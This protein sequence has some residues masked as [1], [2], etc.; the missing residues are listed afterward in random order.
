MKKVITATGEER[1]NKLLKEKEGILVVSSDIQYQEGIIEA[2]DTYP[3]IDMVILKEDIIGELE[4]KELIHKIIMVNNKIEIILIT[5]QKEG[6]HINQNI[7]VMIEDTENYVKQIVSY[8]FQTS[9]IS[10]LQ[11]RQI[12]KEQDF[13]TSHSQK[14]KEQEDKRK[15]RYQ[16]KKS[17]KSKEIITVIGGPGV[18]KNSFYCYNG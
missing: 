10:Q 17:I 2:L 9:E 15:K 16:E 7:K 14:H 12:K 4:L 13:I 3:D 18:R 6:F 11:N 8:F 5:K 1:L